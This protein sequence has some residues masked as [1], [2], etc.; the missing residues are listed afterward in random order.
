MTA[1]RSTEGRPLPATGERSAGRATS[2][3]PLPYEVGERWHAKRDGEGD[4]KWWQQATKSQRFGFSND[5]R[6]RP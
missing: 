3:P 4:E 6:P 2:A 5:E 1:R